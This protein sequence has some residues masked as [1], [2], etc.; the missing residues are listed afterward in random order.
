MK[1][2]KI[3][4]IGDELGNYQYGGS[5]NIVLINNNY[6]NLSENPLFDKIFIN[7]NNKNSE[8]FC[9]IFDILIQNPSIVNKDITNVTNNLKN[10]L[11]TL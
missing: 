10:H 3:F 11:M 1:N 9:N 7:S 6:I 5:T 4:N 8:T 2:K